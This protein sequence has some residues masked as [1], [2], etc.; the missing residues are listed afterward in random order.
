MRRGEI[1]SLCGYLVYRERFSQTSISN[2]PATN[3]NPIFFV[4]TV[5]WI[6]SLYPYL[7]AIKVVYIAENKGNAINS[8][9]IRSQ[10]TRFFSSRCSG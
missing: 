7:K 2:F 5:G 1:I 4:L 3:F 10:R 6:S 9:G 8:G